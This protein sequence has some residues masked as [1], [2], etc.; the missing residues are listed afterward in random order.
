MVTGSYTRRPTSESPLRSLL[1]GAPC[2]LP[3]FLRP[4]LLGVEAIADAEVRVQV[5]PAR[6]SR[7]E[8]AAQLA[9]EDVDRA[10]AVGHR[11]SPHALV[12]ALA[13]DHPAAWDASSTQKLELAAG[14]PDRASAD[15]RLEHVG[16]DLQLP[17][18]DGLGRIGGGSC[19]VAASHRGLDAGQHLLRMAGLRDP[20]VGTEPQAADALGDRAGACADDHHLR[21]GGRAEPAEIGPGLAAE[22]RRIDHD[23][24]QAHRGQLLDRGRAREQLGAPADGADPLR[25]HLREAAVGV[26]DGQTHRR[27]GGDGVLELGQLARP[28]CAFEASMGL[29]VKAGRTVIA[30]A[31]PASQVFHNLAT[32][33]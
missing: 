11:V 9:D 6:G 15:E 14:E 5:A 33:S 23:R 4:G 2:V 28:G 29:S 26:D 8:L 32:R 17:G 30:A 13:G 31:N 16:P 27:R 20:V 24:V 12:D 22:Q 7:L 19:G 1:A 3:L 25:E 21:R 10:V 18:D